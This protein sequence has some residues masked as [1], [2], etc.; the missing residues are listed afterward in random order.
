MSWK[1]ICTALAQKIQIGCRVYDPT[2]SSMPTPR[3][4]NWSA[5][6]KASSLSTAFLLSI[7]ELNSHISAVDSSNE[8]RARPPLARMSLVLQCHKKA[9]S[10]LQ[11]DQLIFS[12]SGCEDK[13]KYAKRLQSQLL[14]NW[15]R[16]CCSLSAASVC[17]PNDI[18]PLKRNSL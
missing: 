16:K 15:Q 12:P 17:C 1:K 8:A 11:G 18:S 6:W 5:S 4:R 10:W 3:A 13:C 2:W 9:A 7:T 14:Q